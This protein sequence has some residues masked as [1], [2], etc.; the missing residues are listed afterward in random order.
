MWLSPNDLLS[1]QTQSLIIFI[2]EYK[3][4]RKSL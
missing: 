4:Q 2:L 3:N 1:Y